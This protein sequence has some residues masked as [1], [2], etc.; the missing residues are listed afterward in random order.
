MF[1][2]SMADVCRSFAINK[3]PLRR[4]D[5]SN[6]H[7]RG[8]FWCKDKKIVAHA[9]QFIKKNKIEMKSK[10]ACVRQKKVVP[11]QKKSKQEL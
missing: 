9:Q 2:L 10:N 4:L 3:A 1:C 8:G 6:L 11:L 5:P 7:T